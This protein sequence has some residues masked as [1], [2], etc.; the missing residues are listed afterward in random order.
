LRLLRETYGNDWKKL[1]A[2]FEPEGADSFDGL[3]QRGQLWLRPGGN[4]VIVMR[5]FLALAAERYYQLVHDIIRKYDGR[6]L[7]L[8]DR[9]QS[10]YYPEVA[11]AAAPYVDAISCNLNASWHDGS[12]VRFQ[13]DTLYALTEKPVV[14]SEFYMA[15]TANRSGDKNDHGI[16]PVAP[17]Q[18]ERANGI[19]TTLRALV[20]LPYVVGADW[21]QYFDEP[22]YGRHDG[23]NFNFGLVDI[24]DKAYA[25]VTRAF[26]GA[27]LAKQKSARHATR[28][29]VSA[30]VPRAPRDPFAH[31]TPG[32]ALRNWDRE[33]GF[34]KPVSDNPVADLY[35]CW[36]PQALYLGLFAQDMVEEAYYRDKV[37]PDI[38]RPV[39]TVE[40]GNGE[41]ISAR[42]GAGRKP[43]VSDPAVRVENLSGVDL[44]VRN[45]AILEL[46][47][48]K[49]GQPRLRRGDTIQ[50]KSFLQ[51]HGKA[52]KVEWEGSFTL[53]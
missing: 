16:F 44:N 30:G 15:A 10:F 27:N 48:R 28:P 39:W 24:H 17:T 42:I 52:Y 5:R 38:D 7:I 51:T 40:T 9:Y 18:R 6:A 53:K 14:V 23:E 45:I 29:D 25:D 35:L 49:L 12:F 34:V 46:P 31:F 32:H 41:A 20:R 33:R 50:L 22:A 36:T 2:D 8:G 1:L 4:G 13:L 11:D 47:T 3:A 37:V 43:I 21:F 26:A 19:R